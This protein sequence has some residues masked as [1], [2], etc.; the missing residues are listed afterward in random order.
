ML[1]FTVSVFLKYV[2][3]FLGTTCGTTLFCALEHLFVTMLLSS[4]KYEVLFKQV[5]L[6]INVLENTR[7]LM[8][9]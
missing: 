6:H 8:F 3:S 4:G 2:D 9:C 5:R 7:L 1:S